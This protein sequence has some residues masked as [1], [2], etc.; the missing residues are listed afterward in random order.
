MRTFFAP[1][2]KREGDSIRLDPEELHHAQTVLRLKPGEHVRVLDGAGG[3]FE[4]S[5]EFSSGSISIRQRHTVPRPPC[6]VVLAMSLIKGDRWDWFLEKSVEIGVA[7]IIPILTEHSLVRIAPAHE[8]RKLARW[9]QIAVGALKQSGQPYLPEI[10]APLLFSDV[11]QRE[12]AGARWILSERGGKRL[13]EVLRRDLTGIL[14]LIG[15]EGGWSDS[16]LDEAAAAGFQAVSLGTQ[17]LRAET[18]PLYLLS[19]IRFATE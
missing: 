1:P 11:L 19:A 8:D 17:I 10:A 7:R 18:A 14:A 16:E 13:Q 2:E 12:H 4:G 9:R 5:L 6:R 15:P 3:S